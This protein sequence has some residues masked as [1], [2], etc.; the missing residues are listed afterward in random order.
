MIPVYDGERVLAA[1]VRRLHSFLSE[2]FPFSWRII[3]ADNA[4][5]DRTPVIAA[6]LSAELPAV[7]ILRLEAKGRGR[8]LRAAWSA[9]DAR[10]VCYMDVDLSTD[11]N[12]LLP[13]VA[14][15]LSDHSDLAIGTRLARAARVTRGAKREFIS[16]SYNRLLRL[17]LRAKFSDAQCGFKAVRGDIVGG[18]LPAVRDEA[19]FFDTEL[20]ILA[21]RRGLRIHEVPVDWVEGPETS[22]DLAAT[23]LADL[24]GVARLAVT[25]P[26]ARFVAVGSVSTAAYA[27][28]LLALMMPLG[29]EAANA[30]A[31]ATTAVANMAANR[32]VTFGMR[33]RE[34]LLGQHAAG[35]L[36]FAIALGLTSGALAV[37]HGLDPR[38]P[39]ALELV[40]LI[41]ATLAATVTRSL[42]LRSWVFKRDRP[43]L[44]RPDQPNRSSPLTG[45]AAFIPNQHPGQ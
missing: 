16:R 6:R 18:L 40:V 13:L 29:S 32:R 42:A 45:V 7:R 11:L 35:A 30:V 44:S 8:A 23:A 24:R 36:V 4:S 28:L 31:L 38:A 2:K 1:S 14:P 25:T 26:S 5:T 34:G 20:L 27:L 33:G 39:H 10:V 41:A 15:L 17:A 12:G 37:L 22:V 9:S 21:Q 19:W 3:I 43:A